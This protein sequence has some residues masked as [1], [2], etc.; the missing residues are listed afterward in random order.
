MKIGASSLFAEW[1]LRD[2]SE[3]SSIEAGD[4]RSAAA[5]MP[6][7]LPHLSGQPPCLKARTRVFKSAPQSGWAMELIPL[8]ETIGQPGIPQGLVQGDDEITAIKS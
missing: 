5:Q 7:E 6:A 8:H 4:R 1:S 3:D 2:R